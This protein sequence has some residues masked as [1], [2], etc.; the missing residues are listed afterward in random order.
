MVKAVKEL[1]GRVSEEAVTQDSKVTRA[2]LC[3]G[4]SKYS[5]MGVSHTRR[6]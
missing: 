4:K 2:T 3:N 1:E 6:T 5:G